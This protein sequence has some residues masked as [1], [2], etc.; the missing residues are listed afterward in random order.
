VATNY[1][2]VTHDRVGIDNG[3]PCSGHHLIVGRLCVAILGKNSGEQADWAEC[4]RPD[5]GLSQ[6][7]VEV[8]VPKRPE[9][10]GQ[11]AKLPSL[12]LPFKI[13]QTAMACSNASHPQ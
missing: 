4:F 2:N 11:Q 9:L 1:E 12:N 3:G 5:W 8:A 10:V 7:A 6:V 13:T